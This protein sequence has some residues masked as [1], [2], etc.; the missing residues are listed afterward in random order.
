MDQTY[1]RL[2]EME[3]RMGLIIRIF[4]FI[5]I[6]VSCLGLFGLASNT[7]E[8][9]TKE[10]GIRKILGASVKQITSMLSFEFLRWVMLANLVSWP[11]AW[12]FMN[13]WLS[14]FVYHINISVFIFISA[15]LIGIIL[16][17]LTVVFQSMNAAL[18]N[19]VETL[20]YE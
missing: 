19:P 5:A 11:L 12:Y 20:R 10:I 17:F 3:I 18:R 14:N 2:Y 6:F 7:I 8:K 15:G 1:N 13:Q 4:T 9:R 16:A